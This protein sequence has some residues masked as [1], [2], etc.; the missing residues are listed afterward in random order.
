MARV[1][2]KDIKGHK[3]TKKDTNIV[4]SILFFDLKLNPYNDE[5]NL[6]SL[7]FLDLEYIPKSIPLT[8]GGN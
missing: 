2:K 1:D 3:R 8:Q 4:K 5:N 6:Q 7:L